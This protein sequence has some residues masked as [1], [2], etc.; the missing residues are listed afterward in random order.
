[1]SEATVQQPHPQAPDAIPRQHI[2]EYHI[3]G[4]PASLEGAESIPQVAASVQ[5]PQLMSGQYQ[6]GGQSVIGNTPYLSL[7]S[8]QGATGTEQLHQPIPQSSLVAIPQQQQAQQLQVQAQQLQ[9]AVPQNHQPQQIHQGIDH[10]VNEHQ[11]SSK[12]GSNTGGEENRQV[13]LVTLQS[14]KAPGQPQ[15]NNAI[16]QMVNFQHHQSQHQQYQIAQN[17]IQQ[18]NPTGATNSGVVYNIHQNGTQVQQQ[19]QQQA[20]TQIF[21]DPNAIT[22]AMPVMNTQ[23]AHQLKSQPTYVN[24]KQYER[25]IKRREARRKLE[26]YYSK[27]RKHCKDERP[28]SG[29]KRGRSAAESES[30]PG[31]D[32]KE[33]GASNGRRAYIHESRHKHAM[34]RP[35]GPGGR[36]LT[37]VSLFNL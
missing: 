3:T 28:K 25:I 14:Q 37:K 27:R 20:Q 30:S 24:A 36:F 12:P 2:S 22:Q 6:N 34:K 21:V 23:Q 35:R 33:N 17:N 13:Q 9:L 32:G 29:G 19:P 10:Q 16:A 8:Q 7:V 4:L 5:Q 11:T 26:E 31:P 18:P 15:D 1:M